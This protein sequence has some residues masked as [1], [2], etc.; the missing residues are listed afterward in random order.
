MLVRST[1]LE[2][3]QLKELRAVNAKLAKPLSRL[4]VEIADIS[5]HGTE[6]TMPLFFW[7]AYSSSATGLR[8]P[9][10]ALTDELKW[11]HCN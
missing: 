5:S 10:R 2:E 9:A 11:T 8:R 4:E 1:T 7:L 6:S 3:M